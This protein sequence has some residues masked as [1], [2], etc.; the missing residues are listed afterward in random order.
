MLPP[1]IKGG[2]SKEIW[3]GAEI[4]IFHFLKSWEK[5]YLTC[6]IAWE[7]TFKYNSIYSELLSR[8]NSHVFCTLTPGQVGLFP[9]GP[10]L[11]HQ[12]VPWNSLK[13]WYHLAGASIRS[14]MLRVLSPGD[15][16]LRCQLQGPH[17]TQTFWTTNYNWG[18]RDLLFRFN[19]VPEY[20]T[21]LSEMLAYMYWFII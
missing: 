13:F 4:E 14:C 12:Q 3:I 19:N 21:E 17:S 5:K 15:C 16:L 8:K 10:V 18:S 1:L 7:N 2:N 20:L 11:W 9:H 6:K